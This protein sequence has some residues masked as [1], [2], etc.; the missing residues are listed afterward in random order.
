MT[1]EAGKTVE[2]VL[3]DG[4]ASPAGNHNGGDLHFGRSGN[5]ARGR[6]RN[7]RKD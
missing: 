6:G 3:V 4:I 1:I 5:S 2:T 7:L